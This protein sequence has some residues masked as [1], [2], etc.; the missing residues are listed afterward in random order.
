MKKLVFVL[1]MVLTL[2]LLAC[3]EASEYQLSVD[4][5]IAN[6]IELFVGEKKV[7]NY[8]VT[9]EGTASMSVFGGCIEINGNEITAV[10][11][12]TA[13]L[14]ISC[15]E[16]PTVEVKIDVTVK[17]EDIKVQEINITG[18]EEMYVGTEQQLTV[19]VLPEN[20]NLKDLEWTSSDETKATV[21]SGIVIALN[22]GV[23]TIKAT[24]KDGSLV[25][26]EFVIT[27]KEQKVEISSISISGKS[28]MYVGESQTLKLDF[29]PANADLSDVTWLSNNDE[30]AT[31]ENGEVKALKAGTVT[32]SASA[33]N[34]KKDTFVITVKEESNVEELVDW[35]FNQCGLE[36]MDEIELPTTHP[37]Y[38]CT[39]TWSSSD[40]TLLDVD[41]G[42][43]EFVEFDEIVD[44]TCSVEYEGN[45]YERTEKFTIRGYAFYDIAVTF[46]GQFKA[47]V[48]TASKEVETVYSDYYGGTTITWSSSNEEIFDNKGNLNKPNKDTYITLTY[49]VNLGNP[50]KSST[51][52]SDLLVYGKSISEIMGSIED[53]IDKN[54]GE[55]G[56]IGSST[57]L[58]KYIDEYEAE[59]QWL[60][61]YGEPLKVEAYVG[62]PIFSRGI[63]VKVKVLFNGKVGYIDLHYANKAEGLDDKWDEIELFVNT[64][65][66]LPVQTFKYTLI[67]WNGTTYGY[68]PFFEQ[69]SSSIIEKILPYTYGKQRTG[70]LKTSTEYV[71]VHDTGNSKP[72]ATAE[73]HDRYITNLNNDSKSTSISWHYT[74]DDS[75][76]YQHLPLD[77]VAW[78]AG[79]GS[80]VFGDI[81]NSTSYGK[82]DCIGGGNRNG[83][84]IETCVDEGSDYTE[85]MRKTAKL[86]AELLVAYNLNIDRVKQ[87]WHFSGKNCPQVM[88]ENN[89]WDEFL[90]LVQIEYYGK[91]ALK[92]VTFEWK[93]NSDCL[94]NNGRVTS[95]QS[96]GTKL[97]YEVKVTYKGESKTYTYDSVIKNR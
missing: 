52:T 77:E 95:L 88:R 49:T 91:T 58:P 61:A 12:G 9:E 45:T 10:K 69:T 86:V 90:N 17:A 70:I 87:H 4:S 13:V 53:W 37:D 68:V 64:I 20:A 43:L 31:V 74:V 97:S 39:F 66:Q 5:E 40:S 11:E 59:L 92:D 54:V 29:E 35:A 30:I 71:V 81:W 28:T 32:I 75:S 96:A 55:N 83:I 26:K 14:T 2:G 25:E 33:E 57:I 7:I 36:G 48:I 78:H 89:R 80:T 65:N 15:V 19:A 72:G 79:D 34:G 46:I 27:V 24:S 6:G 94:D 3:D 76:I 73:M 38:D 82:S 60:D 84:G 67:T 62:N 41:E 44:L 23:V 1:L 93:S 22:P 42:Y 51:F 50:K 8:T 56:S 85:T 63:D 18:K 21:N 16:D 47:G